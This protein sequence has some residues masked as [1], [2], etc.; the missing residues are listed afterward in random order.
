MQVQKTKSGKKLVKFLFGKYEEI[1]E[2][3]NIVHSSSVIDLRHGHQFGEN[4]FVDGDG[5]KIIKIGN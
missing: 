2:D 4:D 3:W 1:P 5:I